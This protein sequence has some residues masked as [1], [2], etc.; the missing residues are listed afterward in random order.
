L[1]LA[2]MK[3]RQAFLFQLQRGGDFRRNERTRAF[4]HR[5]W[6]AQVGKEESLVVESARVLQQGIIP[7]RRDIVDDGRNLVDRRRRHVPAG[8]EHAGQ[9]AL[10]TSLNDLHP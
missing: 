7:A 10:V 6:N 8:I 1:T 5:N 2:A 9:R 4:E 3:T